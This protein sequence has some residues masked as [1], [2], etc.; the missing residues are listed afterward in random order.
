MY[1]STAPRCRVATGQ[2]SWNRNFGGKSTAAI[3]HHLIEPNTFLFVAS[4]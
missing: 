4:C 2:G 3:N 1:S